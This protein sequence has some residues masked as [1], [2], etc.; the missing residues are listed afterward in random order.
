MAEIPSRRGLISSVSPGKEVVVDM[1]VGQNAIEQL[2]AVRVGSL[3]FKRIESKQLSDELRS[4]R[5]CCSRRS[6]RLS[7]CAVRGAGEVGFL[8]G[9]LAPIFHSSFLFL[10]LR[11]SL[12]QPRS[13]VSLLVTMIR[14][15]YSG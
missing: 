14:P 1:V 7:S 15:T 9:G 2:V 6:R 8:C 12:N 13:I 5:R 10:F 4:I 3:V 11:K